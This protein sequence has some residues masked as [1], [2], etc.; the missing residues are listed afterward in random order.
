MLDIFCIVTHFGGSGELQTLPKKISTV[1]HKVPEITVKRHVTR[2][3]S[4]LWGSVVLLKPRLETDAQGREENIYKLTV[5]GCYRNSLPAN[6]PLL[7][8]SGNKY[9]PWSGNSGSPVGA[10]LGG[11][12]SQVAKE[13]SPAVQNA[14][15][16]LSEFFPAWWGPKWVGSQYHPLHRSPSSL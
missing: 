8:A 16:F 14:A 1:P 10:W 9:V 5:L 15:I 11:G 2:W 13:S 7:S 12:Q 6:H 4:W 3:S